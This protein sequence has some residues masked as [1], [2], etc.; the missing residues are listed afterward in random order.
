MKLGKTF[1]GALALAVGGPV[2]AQSS[3]TLYGLLDEG[4][5]YANNVQ[6][7]QAGAPHGR[8]GASQFSMTSGVMQA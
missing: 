7:A 3:V 1:V 4:I 8:T 6:A 2:F 5:N